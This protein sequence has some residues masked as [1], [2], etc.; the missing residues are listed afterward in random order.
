MGRIGKYSFTL[1]SK[2]RI[3]S[4][5]SFVGDKEGQGPLGEGFD[6]C[7]KD[8]TL[9]LESWEKAESRMFESA[10]RLALA[11]IGLETDAL[12]CLIGGDLL[13]QIISSGFAAREL[14]APFLG[15]YSACSTITES[16]ML[17]GMLIEGGFAEL[18][19]CAASSHFSSVERQYRYPLEMG[20]QSTPT[21]QRTVTGAGCVLLQGR[22]GKTPPK[23]RAFSHAAIT[24]GTMGIVEDYG[25]TDASNMGAAM[26]P[27][28][29]KTVARHL[30]DTG[31]SPED[32]D[33][34]LTG[35]LGRF[36]TEMLHEL[37]AKEGFNIEAVH[38]DC[39]KL[40][41]GDDPA[42]ICGGSGAG[43]A[44]SVFCSHI[45]PL[46]DAGE[47]KRVLFLAT[48]ALLS[49]LS[50]LQGESIPAIAHAVVVEHI[51]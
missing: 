27:A 37:M 10:V 4:S 11:K 21:A 49:P 40:V 20:V 22:E 51:E 44:P 41:F 35:D 32:L 45:L 14:K 47:Y 38:E 28:A 50:S 5:A 19:A 26:A 48:G 34:I 9:G 24:G 7:I 8:D 46:I 2:P 16:M 36:G 17:G 3:V 18:I 13:N 42:V 25:I 12:S 6:C 43:C 31:R 29:V 23:G 15:L 1:D 39:G 33:L 30:E